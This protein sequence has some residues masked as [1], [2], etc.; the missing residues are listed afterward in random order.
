MDTVSS[1]GNAKPLIAV[2][3]VNFIWGFDFIAIDYMMDYVS[4]PVFTLVRTGIGAILL[5]VI[6]LIVKKGIK[7]KKEDLLR[8]FISGAIGMGIYFTAECAG[9]GLTS[10]AFSSLIMATVPVFGLFS[11]RIFFGGKI[12]PVKIACVIASVIGVYFLVAGEPMGINLKGFGIMILAALLW[13]TYLVVVKPLND[14]YDLLTL[15]TGI[16]I[17]GFIVEIPLTLISHPVI[18]EINFTPV[19]IAVTIATTLI[20]I[21]AGEFGYV[22]GVGKLSITMVSIFENVLPLVSVIFSFIIFGTSLTWVQ[23]IGG[24]IIMIAVTL[25]ALNEQGDEESLPDANPDFN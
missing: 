11:D 3:A 14:K 12:T 15:M 20:C 8:V 16:F 22:Y 10:A 1:S 9:T 19:G 2:I 17:S 21:I 6:C 23:I 24:A 5:T 25:L 7:I 13:S 4:A 18:S